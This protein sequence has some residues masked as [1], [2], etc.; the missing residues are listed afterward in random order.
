M[1]SPTRDRKWQVGEHQNWAPMVI[2]LTRWRKRKASAPGRSAS[3]D[4]T[5]AARDLIEA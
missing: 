3:D 2:G 4:G 5:L 1:L